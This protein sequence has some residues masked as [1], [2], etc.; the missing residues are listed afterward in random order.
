M[1]RCTHCSSGEVRRSGWKAADVPRVLLLQSPYR[2]RACG[3]RF[4]GYFWKGAR[5]EARQ[6]LHQVEGAMRDAFEI[7]RER[8][9]VLVEAPPAPN[10]RVWVRHLC[11]WE[12]ALR[13]EQLAVDR[14][15]PARI[16]DVSRGGLRLLA[17]QEFEVGAI[18]S[19]QAGEVGRSF[20]A[21]VKHVT[22]LPDGSWSIGCRFTKQLSEA[23]LRKLRQPG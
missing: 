17:H 10:R 13:A 23:H 4:Y 18:L 9:A 15:F 14:Q 8:A 11:D 5:R 22:S 20:L 3:K 2:C 7:Q 12:G 19:V 21:E 6:F 1:I 16:K